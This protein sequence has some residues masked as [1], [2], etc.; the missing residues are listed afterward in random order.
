MPY[1]Q[2]EDTFEMMNSEL[3]FSSNMRRALTSQLLISLMYELL[4]QRGTVPVATLKA[5]LISN[6]KRIG[7]KQ[8]DDAIG[9]GRTQK[10]FKLSACGKYIGK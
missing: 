2:E 6:H 9:A 4:P 10:R 7:D 5:H 3:F 8:I 1:G